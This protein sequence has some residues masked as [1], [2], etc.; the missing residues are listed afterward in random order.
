MALSVCLVTRNEEE[1]LPRLLG[2][3]RGVADEVIVADTHSTDS[4]ARVAAELGARVHLVEWQDDFAAAR[5]AA[6]DQAT[7][8]WVLWLNPDE[9]FLP[10]SRPALQACLDRPEALAFFVRVQRVDALMKH[11]LKPRRGAGVALT[12]ERC[13]R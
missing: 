9:E 10:E 7:G 11:T 13:Q 8:D 1:S 4:T 12:P 6:L 3:L 2:S 5:N